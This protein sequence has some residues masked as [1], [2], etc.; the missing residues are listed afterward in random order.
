MHP[1]G[2][3]NPEHNLTPAEIE[4]L[5][6][7]EAIAQHGL[8]TYAQVGNALAEIRDRHLY[9]DSHPSFQTYL[10]ERWGVSATGDPASPTAV[11]TDAD[12]RPAA[13]REP[14]MA[15]VNKPCEALARACEQTLSA[16][17]GDDRVGIEIRL[18]VR[19]QGDPSPVEE[20]RSLDSL[21]IGEAIGDALLPMMRWRLT[22]ATG[23]IGEVAHQ[24]E[25][26]A[27]DIDDDARAQLRDD[28]LVL[29]SELA[30]VKALLLEL[31]DWD[32]ELARLLNDELDTDTDAEDDE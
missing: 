26:R 9:R 23:T 31:I 28:V 10:R 5:D 21:E 12:A 3:T 6:R 20:R 18:A 19:K 7:L 14:R 16:L 29:D 17:A 2:S 15:L 32:S 24:L 27:A 1:E 4:N 25:T 30:V 22:E 11:R 13:E 8:G